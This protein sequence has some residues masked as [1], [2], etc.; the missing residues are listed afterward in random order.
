MVDDNT[1]APWLDESYA[2]LLFPR[3]QPIHKRTVV[4]AGHRDHR[5]A[6]RA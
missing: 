3:A 1:L 4:M 2:G 5:R 6:N